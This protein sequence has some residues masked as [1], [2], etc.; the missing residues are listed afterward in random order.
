M[1]ERLPAAA[2]STTAAPVAVEVGGEQETGAPTSLGTPA[3]PARPGLTS[4]SAPSS[5]GCVGEAST[6][7]HLAWSF[8]SATS[9][10]IYTDGRASMG[11]LPS[12]G[13]TAIRFP[14]DGDTH[15]YFLRA[16]GPGG[17]ATASASVDSH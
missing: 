17:T 13:S 11:S 1:G 16:S 6:T 3:S 2:T 8:S 7:V 9:V 15:T 14:C 12:S 4:L 10:V 5:A